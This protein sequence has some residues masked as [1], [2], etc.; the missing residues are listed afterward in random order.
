MIFNSTGNGAAPNFCIVGANG[1]PSNPAPNTIWVTTSTK[2]TGYA[3]SDTEPIDVYDGLLWIVTRYYGENELSLFINGTVAVYP[4]MVKLYKSGEWVAAN[5]R[6][7]LLDGSEHYLFSGALYSYKFPNMYPDNVVETDWISIPMPYNAEHRIS[8]VY[9]ARDVRYGLINYKNNKCFAA[10]IDEPATTV[11]RYGGLLRYANPVDLTDYDKL[12]FQMY[13]DFPSA[14][15]F[16]IYEGILLGVWNEIGTYQTDNLVAYKTINFKDYGVS[17]RD[18]NISLDVSGIS[19]EHIVG[20]G[21]AGRPMIY[22]RQIY[23]E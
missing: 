13:V 19:G 15:N 6:Q 2:I 11:S 5:A 18:F 8:D 17:T 21:F 12:N 9:N 10:G 1:T 3:F 16:E 7:Y 20:I 22:A 4:V 14:T 23:L